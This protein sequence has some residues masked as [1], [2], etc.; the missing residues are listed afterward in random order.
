MSQGEFGKKGEPAIGQQGGK[1]GEGGKGGAGE[2]TGHGGHGGEGGKGAQGERGERGPRSLIPWI[3]LTLAFVI[4]GIV[5]T[6][7]YNKTNRLAKNNAQNIIQLRQAVSDLR[8][9]KV[10]VGQLQR[11]N[12]ALKKALLQARLATFNKTLNQGKTHKAALAATSNLTTIIIGMD[13]KNYCPIP[14]KY[15][16]N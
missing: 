15:L 11:S 16:L 4:V 8:E 6:Y 1:G 9:A 10:N 14:Q 2:P 13:G 7:N 3:V 12:C 5:S